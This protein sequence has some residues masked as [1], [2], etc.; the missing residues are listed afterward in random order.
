MYPVNNWE[1][2]LNCF[3]AC[4]VTD[5]PELEELSGRRII[6]AFCFKTSAGVSI[7]HDTSSATAD[8]ALCTKG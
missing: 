7:K 8:A 3:N 1:G 6:C 2:R 4:I 5:A